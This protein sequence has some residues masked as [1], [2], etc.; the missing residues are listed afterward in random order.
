MAEINEEVVK[1]VM[2]SKSNCYDNRGKYNFAVPTEITVTIT[3]D[4][5]R[6]LIED[7]ALANDER[8]KLNRKIWDLE[9]QVRQ[10]KNK[11]LKALDEPTEDDNE[12]AE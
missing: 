8:S 5:Y 2:K 1:E 9:E 3:L 7:T 6:K 12:E 4:E 11:L 10:L